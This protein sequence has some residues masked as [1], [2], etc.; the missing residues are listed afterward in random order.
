MSILL[1]EQYT[2]GLVPSISTVEEVAL[3]RICLLGC[4][5]NLIDWGISLRFSL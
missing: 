1:L 2:F 3:G 4:V 5:Q